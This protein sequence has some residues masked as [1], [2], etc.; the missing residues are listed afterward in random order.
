MK[1]KITR[2]IYLIFA[3]SSIVMMG[4]NVPNDLEKGRIRIK[5]KEKYLS[6]LPAAKSL[7]VANSETKVLGVDNIDNTSDVIG[8]HRIKRVFPFSLK[9]EVKHRK[10]G[11]HQWFEIEFDEHTDPQV[12]VA[13]YASL[14]EIA[15]A[16][17]VYKKVFVQDPGDPIKVTLGELQ[18]TSG[19]ATK[20]GLKA[21]NIAAKE[22]DFNDPMLP[23]QWHYK[24]DGT[25]GTEGM[26]ID[27][28]K[29]WTQATGRK[30]IIVAVVDGG[31]DTEHEDLKENLWVNEAEMNGEA[32]VDD[33]QNGFIDDFHGT[34]FVISGP[35]TSH[36]HGTHVAGTV[37]A[38]TNNGIGVAGVA[39]GDGSGNG[40][41]LMSCQVF[42]DR[43]SLSGN[44][45]AA[46]VYG[47]DNG[48]VISQN[49]WGYTQPDYYEPEVL[50]AVRYFV[51]EAGHYEGSPMKGGVLFFAAGNDG[52]EQTHFPGSFEEV[53]AVSSIGPEGYPAGYTNRGEWVDVAAPGGDQ[54]Y[55]GHEGGVLSTIKNNEY[56][57]FQGTSMACPH[58]SGIAALVIAKFSESDGNFTANDLEFII[59]NSVDDFIFDHQNKYGKGMINATLA[60]ADDGKIAPDAITDLHAAEVYH[61]AVKLGWTV[62]A[63]EDNFQPA[64]F[65]LAVSESEITAE[66]FDNAQLFAFSNPFDA[67]TNVEV[68]LQGLLKTKDYW[69]AM[70]S[71]DMFN[72]VSAI[73]N[74]LHV[75]T[76]NPPHFMTSTRNLQFDINVSENTVATQHVTFSN[77]GEGKLLWENYI[78]NER[79]YWQVQEELEE[80][81][82]TRKKEALKVSMAAKGHGEGMKPLT[83]EQAKGVVTRPE[84]WNDDTTEIVA[85]MSYEDGT[86]ARSII[87]PKTYNAS[88]SHAT[89]YFID[90][91]FTFNLTHI[92]SALYLET[93]E[94][95]II[96]I[97][98]GGSSGVLDAKTVHLQEYYPDST[99][100]GNFQWH[101]IP[102]YKPQRFED[103]ET[104]WIV[105]H[106]PKENT[107]P[108]GVI[109]SQ[110]YLNH[111][112]M[113]EDG[114]QSYFDYQ[115]E[116]IAS[117]YV[118]LERALSTG[119]DG[120]YVFVTP[121][122]GA[123]DGGEN[124]NVGFNVDA[125]NLTEGKHLASVNIVS[126]DIHKSIMNIEVKVNVSGQ[127]GAIDEETIHEFNIVKNSLNELEI[128]LENI[129]LAPLEI[130]D[131]ISTDTG[132]SNVMNDTLVVHP[133]YSA[134]FRFGY[135][136]TNTGII[137]VP[138]TL[139]TNYG[140]MVLPTK[141][142]VENAGELTTALAVNEITVAADATATINLNIANTGTEENVTFKFDYSEFKNARNNVFVEDI[143]YSIITSD[144]PG[145][146]IPNTWEDIKPFAKAVE[147]SNL[148][149]KGED[150]L[151]EFPIFNRTFEHLLFLRDG[152]I[153]FS[154]AGYGTEDFLF[155]RS[156]NSFAPLLFEDFMTATDVIYVYDFG[157]HIVF[158][159]ELYQG[160]YEQNEME[161]ALEFQVALFRDGTVEYRYKNV[162]NIPAGENYIVGFIGNSIDDKI[163][164]KDIN[165]DSISLKNGD[166]IRFIPSHDISMIT[167]VSE[168]EGLI[169]PGKNKDLSLKVD[170]SSFKMIEGTYTN[171]INFQTNSETGYEK[172]PITIN[173]IGEAD[174]V[175]TDSLAFDW[176]MKNASTT[177]FLEVSNIGYARGEISNV[178]FNG[179]NFKVDQ[180]FPIGFGARTNQ[181]IPVIFEPLTEGTIEEEM[182]I[183][184]SNGVSEKV[185][186]TGEGRAN[187]TFI[188]TIPSNINVTL[189]GGE[190]ISQSF[191]ITTTT[192]NADLEFSFENANVARVSSEGVKHAEEKNINEFKNE[193]GYTWKVSEEDRIQY[194]WEDIK[195]TG[196]LH[197]VSAGE[198]LPVPLK[199][200]FPYYGKLYDS[201]Y[202]SKNGYITV[203]KPQNEYY[204]IDFKKDDGIAGMIAPFWSDLIPPTTDG[205]VHI[206]EEE[207][208]LV[209]QWNEFK[210]QEVNF[211]GGSVTFQLEIYED[212]SIY[213][214]YKDVELYGS[215]MKYGLESPDESEELDEEQAY[216]M[217]WAMISDSTSVSVNP[218][219]NGQVLRSQTKNF[220]IDL[221]AEHVF[222][223]TT[224][225]D[226]IVLKTNSSDQPKIEIPVV[227]NVNGTP[228]IVTV[229]TLQWNN[230]IFDSLETIV[231]EEFV[232]ENNGHEVLSIEKI[233]FN[234]IEDVNLYNILGEKLALN[235]S[236]NLG[237]DILIEPW[238]TVKLKIQVVINE[239][240]NIDGTMTFVSNTNDKLVKLLAEVIES[241]TFDWDAEDQIY[242]SNTNNLITYDFNISNI[243]KN[244]LKYD[245]V[246][247]V[248]PNT[249][250]NQGTVISENIGEILFESPDIID[251]M[252][253]DWKD[254][255]DGSFTP[256]VYGPKLAF[257][258]RY[259]APSGGFFLTHL[260]VYAYA[261]KEGEF[262][263]IRV[264]KGGEKPD[265]GELAF[266][267]N[268]EIDKKTDGEWMTF[269]LDIPVIFEEGETFHVVYIPPVDKKFCGFDLSNDVEKNEAAQVGVS[270]ASEN[271]GFA[272]YTNNSQN[273]KT[274]WKIR[275]TTAAGASQWFSLDHLTGELLEGESRTI[276]ATV[277]PSI[278]GPGSFFGK[279]LAKT[280][281]VQRK[282]DEF[283]VELHVNGAPKFDYYPNMYKDTLKIT[284]LETLTVNFKASDPE[285]DAITYTL[286]ENS[287]DAVT[288]TFTSEEEMA[289]MTFE[290][291]YNSAGAYVWQLEIKDA[292][293]NISTNEIVLKVLDK[294]RAPVF[295]TEYEVIELN[296]AD[297]NAG[298]VV[299]PG[300]MFSD[301]DGDS[302]NVLAGNYTPD[303]VD[304][305]FGNYT[306]GI[307]PLKEGTALLVFGADDGKEDGFTVVGVYV[308]IVND[309]SAVPDGI[310][311][312]IN[313]GVGE[314]EVSPNPVIDA[315]AQVNF[316]LNE[317]GNVT[318][319]LFDIMGRP[320][321]AHKA[322]KIGAGYNQQQV[323]VAHLKTGVY[324][325]RILVDGK[326]F[327][328]EKII[329]N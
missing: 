1:P 304:L 144:T 80:K 39:G 118:P 75:S 38:V 61:N 234:N 194:K 86:P 42:D 136:T 68:T 73:S 99:S 308:V 124:M 23:N 203:V 110:R 292:V 272:W 30:D 139:K 267:Q 67:G 58:V 309:P 277:D 319:E 248:F 104:F 83:D 108:Q 312:D 223:T 20:S 134:H 151:M 293:G 246:P 34:N 157:D 294:N 18:N 273:S 230:V 199:F 29:A 69:F 284:E 207:H 27:L 2:L 79:Y 183:N 185:I 93:S 232:I 28:F 268:F 196:I 217:P 41:R 101:R 48:A 63:D 40:V 72:N 98:R 215:L 10:Y 238:G 70:K 278:T 160:K 26:D 44:F 225:N 50:D 129:G 37:G 33:D 251:Q 288:H 149:E 254:E 224:V 180:A 57:Y 320:V 53:I 102:V 202:V 91:T 174:F 192:S 279:V 231:E 287:N 195:E 303:I 187:P 173:V 95:I 76:T 301:P 266:Q 282:N 228:N 125:S 17:P 143:S 7:N 307:T 162:D 22:A 164:Y 208:R 222:R 212:G 318:I 113:S 81:L 140:E 172:I 289:Q 168:S 298:Y 90:P 115:P 315:N 156:K 82:A 316:M 161:G 89:R 13:E 112:M 87:G 167:D 166:V 244:T 3:F 213:F 250:D 274:V 198:Q 214:N 227:I 322:S 135:T 218:P 276:T 229:D 210:G 204:G 265:T 132:V 171:Y 300:E 329:I 45:A 107:M 97:K 145:G 147:N 261:T 158:S 257:N 323:N 84:F 305:T 184:Y 60:L 252:A 306:I 51:A 211:S 85:G 297:P 182:T 74:I 19:N 233:I 31:I 8:I 263:Q 119:N 121:G 52:R 311:G 21:K 302:F 62:P 247:A 35:L 328:S 169:I 179:N 189:N 235:S 94:P 275:P 188:H 325:V 131:V 47:A 290:T 256:M 177:K 120:S 141:M 106:H 299:H 236:G 281:D 221:S 191:S 148:W 176:H 170:P 280:N 295:N 103:G 310:V 226:T 59:R 36:S 66:N 239:F 9:N 181:A 128:D 15:I 253:N 262:I 153:Y 296:I 130:Y 220:T 249:D 205:G 65:Y 100:I 175:A 71:A 237:K 241:P 138:L 122:N 78:Q 92:E 142:L 96:E 126:N 259:V 200:K 152:Q 154:R 46:I 219:L 155:G 43:A 243:G 240:E 6:N 64:V 117:Y 291:D 4:Q 150:L 258:Q 137:N 56:G 242:H 12:V 163:V 216:I 201:V 206:L 327:A 209:I 178:S 5:V 313:I 264:Y 14:S 54:A 159:F 88:M 111:F 32:G 49:S 321:A 286:K 324:I 133:S 123:I 127:E 193:F 269:P 270:N 190:I 245:L 255:A 260:Q 77:E 285:G 105:M 109:I 146:P 186:L 317:R 114:G 24:N 55:Y 116:Y 16:K 197:Q 271:S 25:N 11:L 165:D 283:N 326:F 314:M